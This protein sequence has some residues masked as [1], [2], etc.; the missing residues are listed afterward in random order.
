MPKFVGAIDVNG[1]FTL[2][3]ADGSA[4]QVLQTN[5]SGTVTWA[6]QSG[7][8]ASVTISDGAPSSPSAG[9]LWFESD[10]GKT[11]IYYGDGSSNQWVEI[12]GASGI[13]G[14]SDHHVQFNNVG[15][16]GGSANFTFDGSAA[17]LKSTLTVGADTDGYDV[18]FFGATTG[19]YMEWDES[20][21][22]LDVT[23]AL[24]VT[25]NTSMVGTLTVGVND[26]GHDVI[27]YGATDGDKWKWDESS[28]AMLVEGKSFLE[29]KTQTGQTSFTCEPWSN[30]TIMLGNYGSV[31]TQGSY[32]TALSWNF[33]RAVDSGSGSP[34]THLDVNSYPQAGYIEIGHGGIN[35]CWE[36]DYENN[37]TD[38]PTKILQMNADALFPATTGVT[39]LGTSSYKY[40]LVYGNYFYATTGSESYPSYVFDGDND[41]GMWNSGGDICFS[42]N[43]QD[44]FV[45]SG[46]RK[47]A[48]RDDDSA[49]T[50]ANRLVTMRSQTAGMTGLLCWAEYDVDAASGT[51]GIFML[52]DN[53][54]SS[55]PGTNDYFLLFRRGNGTTIGSIRGTGS[56]SVT[57]N[58]TSDQTMKNDLGDAGDVGSIIDAMKIHKY[59]WKDAAP[60]VGEQIGV[61]A[62]EVLE[63]SGM[64]NG[65]ASAAETRNEVVDTIRDEDGN[66]V[67][68]EEDVYYPAGIDYGKLVPLLVQEIKS[69]RQR[70]ASLEA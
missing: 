53:G 34:F 45:I 12:G 66:E 2:P 11:F 69:L 31:G 39:D 49:N 17:V 33:E 38:A 1:A 58:T 32:R 57:Y 14:G 35:F 22:Q 41:T 50:I 3:T 25:G 54:D 4:D 44:A 23:G 47:F 27:F 29:K 36:A 70:V 67:D 28:D 48:F 18:K 43:G 64:P 30:S 20:A 7:G 9:N 16:L 6:D 52:G 55:N 62:Q 13:A 60:E 21:D 8:G 26:T 56:A 46:S 61:F 51:A 5:G 42:Q 68:V 59:T 15:A 19:K 10:T 40:Q 63:I 65:I 24:D 37:H